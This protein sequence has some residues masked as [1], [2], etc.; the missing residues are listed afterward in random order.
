MRYGHELRALFVGVTLA[1]GAAA[2]AQDAEQGEET[3]DR[4]PVDCISMSQIANT[5][6]VDDRTILFYRRGG[7]IYMN[8]LETQCPTLKSNNIFRYR[9]LSGVRSARLCDYHAITV[10]DRLTN[11]LTHNCRLGPFHPIDQAR[12]DELLR[13]GPGVTTTEPVEL[14]EEDSDEATGE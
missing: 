9:V 10:V 13:I 3:F 5:E 1:V 14:S 11:S 12:A 8:L 4:T 6:I 7:R 2:A